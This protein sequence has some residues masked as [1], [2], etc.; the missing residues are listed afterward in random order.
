[1]SKRMTSL[2]SE[3][4]LRFVKP[5]YYQLLQEQMKDQHLHLFDIQAVVIK[6]GEEMSIS[7]RYGEEFASERSLTMN[8]DAEQVGQAE[9]LN[10]FFRNTVEECKKKIIADY[11]QFMKSREV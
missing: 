10:E 1:M 9:E 8:A 5:D 4:P 7:L 6:N 2:P 3:R 11:Y